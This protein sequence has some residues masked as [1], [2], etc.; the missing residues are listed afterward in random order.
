MRRVHQNEVHTVA[1]KQTAVSEWQN[2]VLFQ[3][4]TH[5]LKVCT[6]QKWRGL[7][8]DAHCG[9][10][11]HHKQMPRSEFVGLSVQ[12]RARELSVSKYHQSVD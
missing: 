2:T 4:H 3:R 9:N 10:F 12:F 5:I 8:N 11:E 1:V 7:A 6:G